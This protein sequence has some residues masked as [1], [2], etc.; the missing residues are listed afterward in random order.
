SNGHRV[1][2]FVTSGS[3]PGVQNDWARAQT[4]ACEARADD[5]LFMRTRESQFPFDV[6][7]RVGS[8]AVQARWKVTQ[9]WSRVLCLL[10]IA[11]EWTPQE[12]VLPPLERPVTDFVGQIQHLLTGWS[13][14]NAWRQ[15]PV[16][17]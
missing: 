3:T 11:G 4:L 2:A 1:L 15:N 14:F 7:P 5:L 16:K 6:P 13:L 17:R 8:T 10:Y 9:D 12:T